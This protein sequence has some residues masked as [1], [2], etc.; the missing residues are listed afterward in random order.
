MYTPK[1]FLEDRRERLHAV[2]EAHSFG[3]LVV[4]DEQGRAEI[5]HLPFVLDPAVG[6][7]GQLRVHVARA[8]PIWKLALA[9]RP[10]VVIFSGPHGYVSPRWYETPLKQVPTWNYAVVHAHGHARGPMSR[11]ELAAL[12]DD[13]VAAHERGAPAP[14]RA[15]EM[16]AD[17]REK[18]LQQIVGFSISIDTLE[19]KFK[20][21]QNRSPADQT[22]VV[23]ALGERGYADDAGLV[24]LMTADGMEGDA[25]GE[26]DE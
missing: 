10:T 2:I 15:D 6:P 24:R 5:A 26:R 13:L 18:L 16:D 17:L 7:N 21:S 1:L 11:D 9:S 20:L 8:N 4:T 22:R 12:L 19:G 23:H 14:W 3:T 25:A